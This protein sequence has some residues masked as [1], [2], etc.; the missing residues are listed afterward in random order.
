LTENDDMLSPEFKASIELRMRQLIVVGIKTC[1]SCPDLKTCA[2]SNKKAG[3]GYCKR[4]Q[5]A[6]KES[7]DISRVG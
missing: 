7:A 5:N 2:D 6:M 1:R 3:K 4:L